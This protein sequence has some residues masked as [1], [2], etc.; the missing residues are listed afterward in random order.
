M[1]C[2]KVTSK[3][4]K[5]KS[6]TLKKI[7]SAPFYLPAYC[8]VALSVMIFFHKCRKHFKKNVFRVTNLAEGRKI[9]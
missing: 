4:G 2:L 3:K 9:N 1:V 7:S 6:E 8:N 5:R